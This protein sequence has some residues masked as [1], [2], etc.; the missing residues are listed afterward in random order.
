MRRLKQ[1]FRTSQSIAMVTTLGLFVFNL[2]RTSIKT[3]A[4]MYSP[5]STNQTAK[6]ALGTSAKK[7]PKLMLMRARKRARRPRFLWNTSQMKRPFVLISLAFGA[8]GRLRNENRKYFYF[9]LKVISSHTPA[10]LYLLMIINETQSPTAE[11]T[12]FT[13]MT[14]LTSCK[15]NLRKSCE[16]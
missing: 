7:N 8:W 3:C 9:F 6:T 5:R 1:L 11:L 4:M 12:H 16:T 13:A 2:N 10:F 14:Y 15:N